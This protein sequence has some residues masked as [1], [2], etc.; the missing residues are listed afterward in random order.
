M[1]TIEDQGA[2][3]T[4][5]SGVVRVMT[6]S[7]PAR[8]NALSMR[9]RVDLLDALTAANEDDGCHAIVLTGEGGM[10]SS[11]GDISSFGGVTPAAG[12]RRMQ[13]IH[14]ILRMLILGPKPVIAAVEGAAFGAGCSLAAASDIVVAAEDARFSCPFNRFALA[15]DWGAAWTLPNRMGIGRA[16]LL[17]LSGRVFT[18]PDAERMGLVDV[19]AP[20]GGALETAMAVAEDV[21]RG[22]PLSNEMIKNLLG[23]GLSSL[24]DAMAAETDAQ[25]VLYSTEDYSEGHAAF[26]EKRQPNFKGR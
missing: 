19:M 21:V 13:G 23:R 18:C 10:F 26:R 3:K 24:E 12:R 11:G 5:Q 25:A 4:E 17:M 2:V 9:M 22:A 20:A 16:K 6:L 1:K 14:Q 7:F 15:A 8:R